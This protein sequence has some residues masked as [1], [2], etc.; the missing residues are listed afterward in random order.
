MNGR[1]VIAA[2]TVV[3]LLGAGCLGFVP[4]ASQ[5]SPEPAAD[6]VVHPE[7]L[8]PDAREEVTIALDR[9]QYRASDLAFLDAVN[10]SRAFVVVH[11][12]ERYWPSV[13]NVSDQQRREYALTMRPVYALDDVPVD[14]RREVRAAMDAGGYE[15]HS[16]AY[17]D[18]TGDGER[19]V[20]ERDGTYYRT[21]AWADDTGNYT[22]WAEPLDSVRESGVE[23]C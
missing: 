19:P 7:E 14:V 5:D 23:H 12:G 8:P 11:E 9:G 16:L 10:A 1:A 18:W 4:P 17:L 15:N 22:L 13:E 2:L 21:C 6:G 20:V 3:A